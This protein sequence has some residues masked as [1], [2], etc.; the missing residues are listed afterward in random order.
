MSI[1]FL[2]LI[3]WI[4]L[5]LYR[6]QVLKNYL[7]WCYALILFLISSFRYDVGMDF[8]T[9]KQ[10]FENI[11][12]LS[13]FEPLSSHLFI[14]A[15][16]M[17][18]SFNFVLSI[19]SFLAIYGVFRFFKDFSIYYVIGALLFFA[20]PIFY[21]QTFN[22][23]RQWAAIG[24]MLL[25]IVYF[26]K[27]NNIKFLFLAGLAPML[28][29]STLFFYPLFFI[30]QIRL[31]ITKLVTLLILS[32][33]LIDVVFFL[34]L[35]TPYGFYIK[36]YT[37]PMNKL[38]GLVALLLLFNLYFIGYF[39]KRIKF[40]KRKMFICSSVIISCFILIIGISADLP[41][42]IVMR[43]NE[44]FI[45]F[46][47]PFILYAIEKFNSQSRHLII[48][49]I[50]VLSCISFYRTIFINGVDDNLVPYNS[51]LFL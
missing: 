11:S 15:N 40:D 46:Y 2:P 43:L 1:Y 34:I 9:Y 17:S 29:F 23:I 19:F 44:I 50:I 26:F 21:F 14:F 28:H 33:L 24:V 35:Q 38:Y 49:G 32:F 18:Y 5:G 13:R 25:S 36:T 45:I 48:F 42:L 27:K 3:S 16:Q 39:D 41:K 10:I 51:I 12:S 7:Y 20:L 30:Y 6:H 8:H 4:A 22:H 31:S 37:N 47:I